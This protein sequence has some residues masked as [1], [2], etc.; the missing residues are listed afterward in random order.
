MDQLLNRMNTSTPRILFLAFLLVLLACTVSCDE[1]QDDIIEVGLLQ[2]HPVQP[3]QT[4]PTLGEDSIQQ[5]VWTILE[6]SIQFP[7][8]SYDLALSGD[9]LFQQS[10]ISLSTGSGEC[11]LGAAVAVS[12]TPTTGVLT[13]TVEMDASR[14]QQVDISSGGDLDGDGVLNE[15]DNC[16]LV[17]NPGQETVVDVFEEEIG[18][19]CAFDTSGGVGD[20]VYFLDNELDEIPDIADNCPFHPNPTQENTPDP[21]LPAG[22]P[23]DGIGDACTESAAVSVSGQTTFSLDVDVDPYVQERRRMLLVLDFGSDLSGMS[24]NWVAGSCDLDPASIRS[25]VLNDRL[26]AASGCP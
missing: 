1:I 26:S 19:A 2:I 22:L 14:V 21:S 16:P 7:E 8:I 6:A 18:E 13:F 23:S 24:C 4:V 15:D 9:C 10:Y 25:C 3:V 12:P 5:T 11:M 17:T 20:P